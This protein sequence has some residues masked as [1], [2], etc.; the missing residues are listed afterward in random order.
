[1]KKM[2]VIAVM[3]S[4]MLMPAQM[5]AKENKNNAKAKIENRIGDRREFKANRKEKKFMKAK[6]NKPNNKKFMKKRPMRRPAPVIVNR[7][8]APRPRRIPAPAPQY[9]YVNNYNNDVVEAAATI[10]GIAALASIIAD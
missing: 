8:P 7:P 6:P 5:M 9:I 4:A 10:V 3:M 2:M 1:M